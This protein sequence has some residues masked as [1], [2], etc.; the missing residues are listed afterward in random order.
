MKTAA[1]YLREAAQVIEE[2]GK[3]RDMPDGERS[4]KRAV[5]A[6]TV[7]RGPVM[8][9]ELDGWLFL[10]A[11]KLA[12]ATA[13]KPHVDDYTDLS[14]YA[15]LAAECLERNQPNETTLAAIKDSYEGNVTKHESVKDLVDS[16][17]GW[18]EWEGGE[19]PV[20]GKKVEFKLRGLPSHV[21]TL[22]SNHLHW[23]LHPPYDN[24]SDIVAYR[25]VD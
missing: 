17:D 5:E 16:L 19:N 9:S 7:L 21:Q 1:D 12:R 11:L 20:P 24:Y 2:R 8:E 18:I 23:W 6:Y 3:L 4:M 13:G 15:A 22:D 25:V 14:G 10:C